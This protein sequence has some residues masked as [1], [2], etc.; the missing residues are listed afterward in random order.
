MKGIKDPI[1]KNNRSLQA[2][3]EKADSMFQM[4]TSI[5]QSWSGD[6]CLK[7]TQMNKVLG[8]M[9]EEICQFDQQ[10]HPSNYD[11]EA[12]SMTGQLLFGMS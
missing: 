1:P 8:R 7:N 5:E 12:R 9:E 2:E 6:R 11:K 4:A 3:S 10:A